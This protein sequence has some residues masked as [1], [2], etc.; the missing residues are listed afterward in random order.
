M[1]DSIWKDSL[2]KNYIF[3]IVVGVLIGIYSVASLYCKLIIGIGLLLGFAALFLIQ[4]LHSLVFLNILLL[5]VVHREPAP[6][7]LLFIAIIIWVLLKDR[8]NLDR[9]L[10]MWSAFLPLVIF[11]L[12]NII[13]LLYASNI[14]IGSRYFGITL[15]LLLYALFIGIYTKGYNIHSMLKAYVIGALVSAGLGLLGFLDLS[16]NILMYDSYRTKALF[17]DPNVLGPFLVP[18]VIILMWDIDRG[19]IFKGKPMLHIVFIVFFLGIVGTFSRGAWVNLVVAVSIYFIMNLKQIGLKNLIIYGVIL[20]LLFAGIWT[21]V[22][23]DEFREFF[24]MRLGLQGYDTQRFTAQRAGLILVFENPFGYG[25]GQ[26]EYMTDKKMVNGISAH[27]LYIRLLVENGILGFLS[28]M[29]L[30][31]YIMTGLICYHIK[32]ASSITSIL[33][34]I[35]SGM[36]IN[37]LVIDTLHWRHLWLFLGFGLYFALEGYYANTCDRYHRRT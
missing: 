25:P 31:I 3:I 13:A 18:A 5:C 26:F 1:R 17:K 10:E 30:I 4:D 15:Y 34:S 36:L 12:I 32:V 29:V 8:P 24:V 9:V 27:N 19:S 23:G 33:I 35:I 2:Y 20:T 21:H 16:P 37:S 11:I 22:I 6:S 7:D 14:Y 28:M